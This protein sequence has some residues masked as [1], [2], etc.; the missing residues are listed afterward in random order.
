M[1]KIYFYNPG[2]IDIRGAYVAGLNAKE[3]AQSAIGYFG[4][5]LKYTI[6]C[7]LR[8]NGSI[9]IYSGTKKYEFVSSDLEFRNKSFKQVSVIEPDGT[10]RDL[11]FTT[12]YGKNWKPWQV[13]REL[14][15]NA[16]DENGD[17]S[18]QTK[19]PQDGHTTIHVNCPEVYDQFVHK[20]LIILPKDV[21]YQVETSNVK[22]INSPSQ[23]L[24]YKGVRIFDE[25]TLFTYNIMS[26][27]SITEDRTLSNIW[28][29]YAAVGDAIMA[30]KDEKIIT[31]VL[32][33]DNNFEKNI[34][35]SA[36]KPASTT[37]IDVA[38]RLW[39]QNPHKYTK[40]ESI[41][42][43]Y[44]SEILIPP[45]FAL[46]PIQKK[47]LHK[48][49]L[50]VGKMGLPADNHDISVR[51]LGNDL[52][53]KYDQSNGKIYLSPNVFHQGTKQVVS[54]LYEE[55]LHAETGKEDCTYDMQTFLFNKI[56][57]LYEEHVFQEPI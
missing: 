52:L 48:A 31:R 39:K 17:V 32:M 24:Y 54:T 15:S 7:I 46:N 23:F 53:G 16:I 13:F 57:S 22:I 56:V 35:L 49:I 1:S 3:D 26:D 11:G 14:Y 21:S 38:A 6:A 12:E 44:R 19:K 28:Y 37:F 27:L 30:C 33:S 41:I 2:E 51:D 50:L 29:A 4:T 5:G 55:V 10:K 36:Y 34:S 45:E 18:T 43:K 9:T 8:W 42:S 47:Q 25:P 40:L 20:D